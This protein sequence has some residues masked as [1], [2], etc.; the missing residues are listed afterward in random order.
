[1]VETCSNVASEIQVLDEEP[2]EFGKLI[3]GLV[4]LK[5]VVENIYIYGY[6]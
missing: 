1:M 2:S 6:K 3:L 4:I 5:Y